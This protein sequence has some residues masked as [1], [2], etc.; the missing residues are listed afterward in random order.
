M[1]VN[2]FA[3]VE[4]M[5][6]ALPVLCHGRQPAF[7]NVSSM[8]G[9]RGLPAWP[10]YSASKYA[11]VGMTEALRGE[12]ARFDIDVLL[13]LP[14]LTKSDL[15]RN[16]LRNEGKMKI[17]FD[18]GMPPETVASGILH[19]LRKN[20]PETVIGREAI[21]ML[22]LQRFVPRLLDW[23]IDRRVRKLYAQ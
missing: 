4:L 22:R 3:P 1:E 6:L 20:K 7:V 14:G 15:G 19:A 8:C 18:A 23:L 11:L 5:R 13:I 2:F 9:R 21:W 10:E 17:S 12:M 16:L